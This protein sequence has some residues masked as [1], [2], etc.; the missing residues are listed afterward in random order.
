MTVSSPLGAAVAAGIERHVT[1][2][3]GV[4][5][6]PAAGE[7]CTH[8]QTV[9]TQTLASSGITRVVCVDIESSLYHR[10]FSSMFLIK[11]QI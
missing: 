1:Y 3:T 7:N 4:Q 9:H 2:S 5:L 6:K 11:N 8:T 10:I